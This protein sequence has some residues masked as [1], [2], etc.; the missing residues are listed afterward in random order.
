MRVISFL[1]GFMMYMNIA[2]GERD[3]NAGFLESRIDVPIEAMNQPT[4]I[5]RPV[6]KA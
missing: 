4:F 6:S 3:N 2:L 5:F 1:T